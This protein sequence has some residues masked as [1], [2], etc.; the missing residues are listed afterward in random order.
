M[1]TPPP[2][3]SE[4]VYFDPPVNA[5]YEDGYQVVGSTTPPDWS[6]GRIELLEGLQAFPRLFLLLGLAAILHPSTLSV[7]LLLGLTGWIPMARLVRSQVR[8]LTPSTAE[9]IDAAEH[10][11][12]EDRHR[13][14]RDREGPG[15]AGRMDLAGGPG[16]RPAF[17]PGA[18][19]L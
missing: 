18:A 5:Q 11:E 14:Q 3:P 16:G 6:W 1:D 15:S 7:V 9:E 10:E 12:G 19:G 4:H 2:L 8:S 17:R 13:R